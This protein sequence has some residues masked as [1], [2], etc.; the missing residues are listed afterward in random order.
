[1]TYTGVA[2]RGLRWTSWIVVI[3]VLGACSS[4][5]PAD[6]GGTARTVATAPATTNP[7]AVPEVVDVA[8]VNRVLAGLDQVTGDIVRLVVAAKA[9]PREALER[10]QAIYVDDPA[11]PDSLVQLAINGIEASML[12]GFADTKE[13]PGNTVTRVTELIS[14]SQSC[15]FAKVEQDYSAVSSGPPPRIRH[16]WVGLVPLDPTN[17]PRHY[18]PTSWVFEVNGVR[19][20]MSQPGNPCVA[21]P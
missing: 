9:I 15:I 1:M 12:N 7:Y 16:H 4:K 17:D 13:Q 11:N 19:P 14:A 6:D 5:E 8:Y 3:A 2:R 20:D 10:L 18:N 21:G